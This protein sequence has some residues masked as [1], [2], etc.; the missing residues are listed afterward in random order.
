MKQKTVEKN[1]DRYNYYQL[2]RQIKTLKSKSKNP[3][4]IDPKND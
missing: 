4:L 1:A 3:K 2:K